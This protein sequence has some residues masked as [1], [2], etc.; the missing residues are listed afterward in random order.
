MLT[1]Y[2]IGPKLAQGWLSTY[3]VCAVTREIE[4]NFVTSSINSMQNYKHYKAIRKGALRITQWPIEAKVTFQN[5]LKPF[6]FL[7]ASVLKQCVYFFVIH[8]IWRNCFLFYQISWITTKLK[9]T[10]LNWDAFTKLESKSA[11]NQLTVVWQ[12]KL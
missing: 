10:G 7:V 2:K 5:L 1:W 3:L 9:R 11:V 12:K 4:H 8:E 6:G